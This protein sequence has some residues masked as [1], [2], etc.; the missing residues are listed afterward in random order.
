[1]QVD[2]QAGRKRG[3]AEEEGTE[4]A[5]KENIYGGGAEG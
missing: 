1:M 5:E 4:E 3:L 2:G